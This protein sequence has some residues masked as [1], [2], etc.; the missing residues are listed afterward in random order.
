VTHVDEMLERPVAIYREWLEK[1]ELNYPLFTVDARHREDV[2]LLVEVII[3]SFEARMNVK[4][5]ELL[6]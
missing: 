6:S 3:A 2:L 1:N 5:G 4:D